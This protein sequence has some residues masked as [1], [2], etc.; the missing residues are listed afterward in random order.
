MTSNWAEGFY[1]MQYHLLKQEGTITEYEK[2]F[3]EDIKEQT[4]RPLGNVLELGAWDG[5]LARTL[6][7]DADTITTVELVPQMVAVAKSHSTPNITPLCGDFH[8]IELDQTFDT[9]L[10]MD[11]F[12]VGDDEDQLALLKRVRHWL[13]DEGTTII[14]IY[15][16][17][18]WIKADGQ[19]MRPDPGNQPGVQRRYGYDHENSRMI[20]TWWHTDAPENAVSQYLKC[21]T[22]EEI[23]ALCQKAGLDIIAYFPNGAMD[24]NAWRYHDNVSL[25]ECL[26]YRIKARK[27]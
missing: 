21:Y 22:P 3:A 14:D 1:E 16:P 2:H 8:E 6:A 25:M 12:G 24:Y 19:T 11:G 18:H 9:V 7:S 10:Y 26:S 23:Y 15:N 17:T 4:G 20:D 13:D 5:R 27:N